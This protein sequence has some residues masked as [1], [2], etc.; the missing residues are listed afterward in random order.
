MNLRRATI[1]AACTGAFALGAAQAQLAP[2][3]QQAPQQAAPWPDP[4][5]RQAS[6]WPQQAPQQASPWTQQQ[7]PPC[8]PEFTKLRNETEKRGLAI[9]HASERRAPPKVACQLLTAFTGAEAKMLKYAVDNQA[10]CGIPPQIIAS[11]K[12]GHVKSDE[13]RVKVC[14]VAAEQPAQ[15][16]PS[17]SDALSGPV[18][19]SSNIR[20]GR[21]TFDTLTGAPLGR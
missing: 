8:M 15:R 11:I 3:P 12:Q 21:G 10:S 17:L 19:S 18:T 16:G 6:P 7:A 4:A 20:T 9:K 13:L 5:P 2:W 14:R 1:A